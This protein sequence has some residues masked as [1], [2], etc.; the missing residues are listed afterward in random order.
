[1]KPSKKKVQKELARMEI[2]KAVTGRYLLVGS[3][4][5]KLFWKWIKGLC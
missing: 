1:M 3:G 5:S 2:E 4:E